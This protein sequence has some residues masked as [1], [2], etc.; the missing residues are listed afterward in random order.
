MQFNKLKDKDRYDMIDVPCPKMITPDPGIIYWPLK[1]PPVLSHSC[2]VN[3]L[4]SFL[5]IEDF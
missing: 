4:M 3:P 1:C 2:G 5:F